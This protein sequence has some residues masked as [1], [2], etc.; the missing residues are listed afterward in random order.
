VFAEAV[1][2]FAVFVFEAGEAESI[3]HGDEKLVGGERLFEK[4]ESAEFGGFDG[5]FD[6]GLAGDEN[7][8]SFDAGVF[9]V[10]EELDAALAGHYD[11]GKNQVE[12]FGAEK[13]EGAGRVVADSSFMASEA[14]SAGKRGQ[15]VGVVVD[16]EEVSFA[17]QVVSFARVI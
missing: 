17:R 14:E 15:G 13:F 8:G 2:E 16:E 10:F 11:V 7:D 1:A 6:I 12:G 4:I 5:H 3:F 9:E